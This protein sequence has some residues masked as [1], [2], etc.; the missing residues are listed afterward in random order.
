MNP[1][2]EQILT[3]LRRMRTRIHRLQT[4]SFGLMFLSVV[5]VV[6]GLASI[7]LSSGFPLVQT[8]NVVYGLGAFSTICIV[9]FFGRNW[10]MWQGLLKHAHL[11]EE[12][13]PEF[14]GRLLL[15]MENNIS[16]AKFLI[17]RSVTKALKLIQAVNPKH[18]HTNKAL[19]RRLIQAMGLILTVVILELSLSITPSDAFAAFRM[20]TLPPP[21]SSVLDSIAEE[22]EVLLGDIMLHYTFPEHTRMTAIKVPN[23]DGSL[24]APIGTTVHIS[25]RAD[26]VYQ[27]ASLQLDDSDLQPIQLTN[28]RN[29]QT[30]IEIT[31]QGSWRVLFQDGDTWRSTK[32]FTI[33]VDNDDPPIVTI[34]EPPKGHQ[35]PQNKSLK[36][37]WTVSDDFGIERVVLEIEK[38]GELRSEILLS[39]EDLRLMVDGRLLA[40]PASLGLRSGDEVTIRIVAYD[41]QPPILLE[42][43]EPS[44][45]VDENSPIGKRGES[46]SMEFLILGPKLSAKRLLELNEKLKALMIPVL[47][48]F[49]VEPIMPSPHSD[50]MVMW[51]RS[52]RDR[53]IPLQDFIEEEW[54]DSPPSDLSAE[55]ISDVLSSAGRLF[56]FT[57]STYDTHTGGSRPKPEDKE[58]FR[59]LHS[60]EVEDLEKAIYLIDMM[61]QQVAFRQVNSLVESLDKQ[62]EELE[63]RLAGEP[64][65]EELSNQVERIEQIMSDLEIQTASL[66]DGS[67]RDFVLSRTKESQSLLQESKDALS[68]EAEDAKDLLD[69][70]VESINQLADGVE[71]Q[72]LRRESKQAEMME[73]FD[74]LM[75]DLEVLQEEQDEL[76]N[77][78][79]EKRSES[80]SAQEQVELWEQIEQLSEF[81]NN[82][83]EQMIVLIGDGSGFNSRVIRHSEVVVN[84]LSRVLS[85]A[86]A[87][88]R[89]S[90]LESTLNA[91]LHRG[92]VERHLRGSS[93]SKTSQMN[94]HNRV[95]RES[96]EEIIRLLDQLEE[97]QG[98]ADPSNA[99]AQQQG[100]QQQQLK[101]RMDVLE[102]EVQTIEQ[103]L[104]TADG[105]ASEFAEQSGESMEL[106][107]GYLQKG[108]SMS[109][110]GMQRSASQ[111]IQST[112][113]RLQ[114]QMDDFMQMQQQMSKMDPSDP[115]D[116]SGE[117]EEPSD[118]DFD[119][120][121]I[122]SQ[123]PSLEE[124]KT[125][126]EYRKEL[127]EGMSSEVPNEYRQQKKRYYE[128]LVQ[129]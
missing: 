32:I 113:N 64:T 36:I 46:I 40:T 16:G 75:E 41:N 27:S 116:G 67:L 10:F 93:S 43:E 119:L 38:G 118:D 111:N 5:L 107:K 26:K 62:A 112:R 9:I 20:G 106:A 124:E 99:M 4:V 85:A 13:Y 69:Q 97:M 39:P 42:G 28:G 3:F 81:A 100:P 105:S 73:R 86:R 122:G 19:G 30:S 37:P 95:I 57:L 12:M 98:A 58:T 34:T 55:L 17:E 59:T 51:T 121:P 31:G 45:S 126:E 53:F 25:A 11:I 14:R 129:Q 123:M 79:A 71:E 54:G 114:E 87:R 22:R 78:L 103:A 29:I 110:E 44:S 80:G 90:V 74:Q 89:S 66:E 18:V 76:A 61:L 109:G 65:P 115:S 15:G 47:A 33:E 84:E 8:R 70:L 52:A 50:G 63:R 56:R 127:L 96:N 6:F 60:E 49:L 7:L 92:Q 72:R 108:G 94:G 101:D 1:K 88:E 23:S 128:E 35:V 68:E 24:H 125:P 2:S 104:P 21:D 77:A 48:D 82:E 117:G 120:N 91:E 102:K 83:G